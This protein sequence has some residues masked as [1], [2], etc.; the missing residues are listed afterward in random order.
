M[1]PYTS[2]NLKGD[3]TKYPNQIEKYVHPTAVAI[4]MHIASKPAGW[5][6]RA[7]RIAEE[8]F[9]IS[10]GTVEKYLRELEDKKFLKRN[11][12]PTSNRRT[13]DLFY[14]EVDYSNTSIFDSCLSG[15]FDKEYLVFANYLNEYNSRFTLKH[16]PLKDRQ[17]KK[18]CAD[19]NELLRTGELNNYMLR[20][21]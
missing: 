11:K 16:A 17:I 6:F 15:E 3:Y 9:N 14:K 19:L 2:D 4:Y 18:D 12:D 21:S 7:K 1:I 13:Y 8:M 5:H 20:G 10:E